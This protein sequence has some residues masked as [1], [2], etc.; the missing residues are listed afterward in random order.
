[1][2][3]TLL[4]VEKLAFGGAGFG[5][6][7]GK[8][9]F[10]PFTA[11]GDLARIR[12]TSEKSSFIKGELIELET[13]SS[14][15]VTQSCPIFGSCGGCNWRHISYAEQLTQKQDIFT[16]I[17]WRS[18]RVPA[19]RILPIAAAPTVDGYR[20]RVQLKFCFVA[21][22]LHSG[23]FRAGSH[24]IVDLP[25]ECAIA[26][27]ALNKI[28]AELRTIVPY[29]PDLARIPQIDL[30]VG[31]DEQAIAVLHYVG[32]R[33]AEIATFFKERRSSFVLLQG[34][35]L[36]RSR[37]SRPV[38]IFG[39]ESLSYSIPENHL[40]GAPEIR[41]A[42][43][44]GGFSQVNYR[45]NLTLIRTVLDWAGLT[46]QERVLDLYCGNG[47]FSVPL[48]RYASEIFGI[49]ESAAS[50]NDARLN[51]LANGVVNAAFLCCD[52]ARGVASFAQGGNTF[53]VVILD[54]PRSGAADVVAL[55]HQ[56]APKSVIYIS[57]DPATLARDVGI[58][59]KFGYD[60]V[61][62]RPVDMFPQTYHLES[63]TLLKPIINSTINDNA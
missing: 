30:T 47:N 16:E 60:V 58:L 31:D 40:P 9:C 50:I 18:G 29:T 46:G 54:P 41:L 17:M 56:L 34:L 8:A 38:K 52:A 48:A 32:N 1:M 19:E 4:K 36:L 22:E 10:V 7:D 12:I 49:E 11:P 63:V 27:A 25:D 59:K 21:G 33:H 57:C 26:Q 61:Q 23:F 42:F 44:K 45:Q 43:S 53:D 35:Y 55:L 62:S 14:T 28:I 24:D 15:R 51:C 39:I 2:H 13:A 6:V 20:S 3:E 37:Q 5:R